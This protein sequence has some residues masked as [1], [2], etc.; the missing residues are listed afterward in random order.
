MADDQN[1]FNE[2][3]EYL[4]KEIRQHQFASRTKNVLAQTL[5]FLAIITSGIC[6]INVATNWFS[7][8]ELSAIAAI[9]GIILLITNTFKFEARSKWNKL[10]Q[11]KMEG[12]YRKLIFENATVETISKE[13]TDELEKLDETRI[14]L[15]KPA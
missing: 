6:L 2:L 1:K 5:F 7:K 15:V 10:K 11:R 12:L 3:K 9:P 4:E 13:I 8:T 14:E